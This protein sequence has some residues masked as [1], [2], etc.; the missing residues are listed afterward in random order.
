MVVAM[1]ALGVALSG[2]AIAAGLVTSAQI[3]D[4]TI[5]LVDINPSTKTSLKGQRGPQGPAGAR[6]ATGAAGATGAQGVAGPAGAK[7][8][9][10]ATGATGPAGPA[11]QDGLS[12]ASSEVYDIQ[13]LDGGCDSGQEKW[14]NDD[15]SRLFVINPSENG[16][17]YLVT[18]YDV[19]SFKTIVGTHF[20]TNGACG[21]GTYTSIQTGHFDGVWT[22]KVSGNLDYQPF[23]ADP[24][25]G[26]WDAFL[27]AH[28][29]ANATATDVGYE[30]D[31]YN[32]CGQHWRDAYDGTTFSGSGT[33]TNC[34]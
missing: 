2:S 33:I 27:T 32:T 18:R 13:Q 25:Q 23:A 24:A 8:A 12:F 29:G 17:E 19:G 21:V 30:F 34:P 20:A 28:F 31:Y 7:G 9:T 10:G 15:E 5:R 11:G 4:G 26:T 14:A 16:L 6:G 3:K 1:I 22:K